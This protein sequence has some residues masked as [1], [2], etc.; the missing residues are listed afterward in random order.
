MENSIKYDKALSIPLKSTLHFKE[1]MLDRR[2][3]KQLCNEIDGELLTVV[4]PEDRLN[5]D[6]IREYYPDFPES[7]YPSLSHSPFIRLVVRIGMNKLGIPVYHTITL[8]EYYMSVGLQTLEYE[9]SVEY[10]PIL[11]NQILGFNSYE[12]GK[13]FKK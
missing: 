2:E 4:S 13:K 6:L 12:V 8:N 1:Y 9:D 3:K 11:P 10:K 7:D 5:S